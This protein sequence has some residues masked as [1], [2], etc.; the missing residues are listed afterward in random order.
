VNGTFVKDLRILGR[1]LRRTII[2]DNAVEAFS[3]QINNGIP[4][5]SWFS[6][7]GDSELPKLA[8]VR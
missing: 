3:Y 7:K 2:V 6:E 8:N 4:I 1:D 5:K